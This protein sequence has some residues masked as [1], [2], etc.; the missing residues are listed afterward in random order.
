[1]DKPPGKFRW[2][3]RTVLGFA[4]ELILYAGFVGAYYWVVLHALGAW[5]K[6][7]FDQHKTLYAVLALAVVV[8]QAGLLELVTAALARLLRGKT[9]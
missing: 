2:T 1:M 7:V 9:N 4:V 5:L 8:A 3:L 6:S